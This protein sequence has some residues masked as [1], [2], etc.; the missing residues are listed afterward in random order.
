[1]TSINPLDLFSGLFEEMKKN[2]VNLY[3][4]LSPV[5][6]LATGGSML[7]FGYWDDENKDPVSA[8]ENL[9]SILS[10]M[11]ELESS[12]NSCRCW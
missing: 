7:N 9:C 11:A 12:K 1:L 2:V 8:Q 5:M 3:N 6:Q 10:T 4:A